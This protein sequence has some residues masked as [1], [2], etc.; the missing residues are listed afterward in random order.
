MMKE[1]IC[2]PESGFWGKAVLICHLALRLKK[3]FAAS[4]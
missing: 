2:F 4:S 1:A 3:K